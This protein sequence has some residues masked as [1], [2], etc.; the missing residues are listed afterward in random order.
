MVHLSPGSLSHV[1]ASINE[2]R[3]STYLRSNF[4]EGVHCFNRQTSANS[5]DPD[6]TPGSV[7]SGQGQ[8]CVY[9]SSSS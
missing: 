9:S 5:V 2:I 6:Q 3:Y 4:L 8:H 1:G 7:A